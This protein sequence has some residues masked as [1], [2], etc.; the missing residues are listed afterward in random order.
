[1]LLQQVTKTRLLYVY[2]IKQLYQSIEIIPDQAVE[3]F[4]QRGFDLFAC[5]PFRKIP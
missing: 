5:Q 2:A 3:T 1:M 4:R